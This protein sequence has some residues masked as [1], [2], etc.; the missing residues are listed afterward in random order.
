M[1]RI[2]NR[3]DGVPSLK[4]TIPAGATEQAITHTEASPVSTGWS[5]AYERGLESAFN[6]TTGQFKAPED[7][8]YWVG[9]TVALQAA[10]S[11]ALTATAG[12]TYHLTMN[13]N[14]YTEGSPTEVS[15]PHTGG[16]PVATAQSRVENDY[17]E[18]SMTIFDALDLNMGDRIAAEVDITSVDLSDSDSEW[19][20]KVTTAKSGG[21]FCW[22]SVSR[23]S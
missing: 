4:Y 20:A 16:I 11:D 19:T 13:L 8:T 6:A 18:K 1:S 17:A 5:K 10:S 12:H 3:L 15:A 14:Y 22:F 21:A 23:L 9:V 2:R 7:G